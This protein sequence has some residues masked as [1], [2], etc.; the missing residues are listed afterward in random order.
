[1]EKKIL[2]KNKGITGIDASIAVTI[3]MIFVP[4]ITTII[5][6]TINVKEKINRK[7]VATNLA[8]QAIESVKQ[9][10]YSSYIPAG[11]VD[12]RIIFDGKKGGH[13]VYGSENFPKGYKV[14]VEV[15]HKESYQDGDWMK[16]VCVVYV[17]VTYSQ[18]VGDVEITLRTEINKEEYIL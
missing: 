7:V 1:M 15:E 8:I 14:K 11:V 17:T 6:N 16:I 18:N 12:N 5:S 4:L 9:I 3:L 13:Y 2:R 10:E